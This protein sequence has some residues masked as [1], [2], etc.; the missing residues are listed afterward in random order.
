MSSQLALW[1]AVS[2]RGSRYPIAMFKTAKEW[3]RR[4]VEGHDGLRTTILLKDETSLRF[5]QRLGFV[6]L[7]GESEA[8]IGV[9]EW[10]GEGE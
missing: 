2:E 10:K 6:L 5:A 3:M 4:F 8:G 7:P 9:M 1:L